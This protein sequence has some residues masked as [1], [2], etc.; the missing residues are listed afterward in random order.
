[1]SDSQMSGPLMPDSSPMTE[2]FAAQMHREISFAFR[3]NIEEEERRA[4]SLWVITITDIM[5]LML[6]FFVMLYTMSTPDE[7]SWSRMKSALGRE[8]GKEYAKPAERGDLDAINID[9]VDFSKGLDLGYLGLLLRQSLG[10]EPFAKDILLIN[11]G[12]GLIVSM[13]EAL[14]FD[15]G[16]ADVMDKGRKA[17]FSVGEALAKMRNA[18]EIVGHADPRPLEASTS[19]PYADNWDL[20]LA[21][22]ASVAAI[23]KSTGYERPITIRGMS[24]ARYDELPQAMDEKQRLDLSRRVDIVILNTTGTQLRRYSFDF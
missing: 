5:A 1:M 14:L 19:G 3:I 8:L 24:S 6:T 13:P 20:S 7:Q 2:A 10:N 4:A 16:Q 23:L 11:R 17:L 15:A 18:I 21:R 22:A 12:D 9:K